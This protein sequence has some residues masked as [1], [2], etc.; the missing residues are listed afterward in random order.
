MHPRTNR[1]DGGEVVAD[2]AA[3]SHGLGRFG[4]GGVDARTVIH[5]LG[6]GVAHRLHKA[7]DEGCRQLRASGG[8]D[9]PGRHEA[10]FQGVG[11]AFLP[12]R[13]LVFGLALRQRM[14]HPGMHFARAGLIA[15]GVFLQQH[16]ARDW[17]LAQ[18]PGALRRLVSLGL[19]LGKFDKFL[20]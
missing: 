17:L 19:I 8:I 7:I 20:F 14:R 9:A 3:A 16:F 11:K 18:G 4:Q 6:D 12:Q 5:H 2:T 15:L 13:T 10:S 1:P